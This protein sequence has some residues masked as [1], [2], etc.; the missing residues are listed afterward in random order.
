MS[1]DNDTQEVDQQ[2]SDA[3][4]QAGFAQVRGLEPPAEADTGLAE[5][6]TQPADQSVDQAAS[7]AAAD[8]S[9]PNQEQQEVQEP[10][11]AGYKE[12]ELR[13]LLARLPEIDTMKQSLEAG[14]RKVMGKFGEMQ[15]LLATLTPKEGE[16]PTAAETAKAKVELKRLSAEFPELHAVL[17]ED[18]AGFSGGVSPEQIGELV[19]TQVQGR[20]AAQEQQFERKLLTI[21]HPDWTQIA[22]SP[23]WNA[24]LETLPAEIAEKARTS[25][26]STFLTAA[27]TALKDWKKS[28]VDSAAESQA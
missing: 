25:W 28:Q 4:M 16:A 5:V 13:A 17:S 18:L 6:Q 24:W 15:R 26:D 14:N 10:V 22:A 8:A 11:I 27:F 1:I 9:A 23:D 2:Q 12:S 19:Q 7:P 3:G 20:L 21:A